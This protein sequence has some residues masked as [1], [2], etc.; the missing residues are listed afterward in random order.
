[1]I[2]QWQCPSFWLVMLPQASATSAAAKHALLAMS[3]STQQFVR[4]SPDE[5]QL[6]ARRG[7]V[8]Y[9]RSCKMLTPGSDVTVEEALNTSFTLWC[10]DWFFGRQD[11][12]FIHANAAVRLFQSLER[13]DIGSSQNTPSTQSRSSMLEVARAFFH[14]MH[15]PLHNTE[16]LKMLQRKA[17][18]GV[19]LPFQCNTT[20]PLL[21][22]INPFTELATPLLIN[23]F[24]WLIVVADS[25]Q[26]LHM[27]GQALDK[28]AHDCLQ[29][30][31]PRSTEQEI[32]TNQISM[33][34]S[35]CQLHLDKGQHQQPEDDD[36]TMSEILSLIQSNMQLVENQDK[37][38]LA[39]SQDVQQS[40]LGQHGI[41]CYLGVL[42]LIGKEAQ[43]HTVRAQAF[44]LIA[45]HGMQ[46]RQT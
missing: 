39:T 7:D 20:N 9:R 8:H 33:F 35:F 26:A 23:S 3:T 38:L 4:T 28:C 13:G 25:K 24:F 1:M 46:R 11:Q 16:F 10:Y 21:S 27:I 34:Q 43:N 44:D 41:H 29:E 19:E 5:I 31:L 18:H 12:S 6:M 42:T 30:P 15:F 40:G 14:D 2:A 37:E 22:T 32:F 36:A 17:Q 45:S